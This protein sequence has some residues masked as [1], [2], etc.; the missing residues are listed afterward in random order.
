MKRI[1]GLLLSCLFLLAVAGTAAAQTETPSEAAWYARYWN[2]TTLA[3]APVLMRN[4]VSVNHDWGFGSPEGPV[5]ADRFSARWTSFVEFDAGTY[6]FSLTSDDGARLWVD[7][8]YVID[9]WEIRPATTDTAEV[10]LDAGSHAVAVEYFENTGAAQV[11]L[12]WQRV[13]A[14]GDESVAIS[15]TNGPVGS[16]IAVTATGYSPNVVATVGIGR[17]NS[18]PTT[19]QSVTTDANGTLAT[20]IVL[21]ESAAVGESWV[22]LV[23]AG[24]ESALSPAF[25]VTGE[26]GPGAACGSS[27]VVQPNDWLSR[28]A[29]RCDTTVDAILALNPQISSA[30]VINVG[31]VL[32]LPVGDAAEI[33]TPQI[34][35]T[36]E[37]GLA[38]T[39]VT[40]NGI[41]F[42]AGAA[43]EVGLIDDAGATTSVQ[44]VTTAANGTLQATL[45]IAED[46][47]LGDQWQAYANSGSETVTSEPFTVGISG[48]TAVPQ[49]NLNLRNGPGTAFAATDVV[50]VGTE[51]TVTGVGPDGDW[52]R[53]V[54]DGAEGWIAGWL[55]SIF[56]N[57]DDV[58]VVN[59]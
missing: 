48:V 10:T 43:V 49:F 5:N 16:E 29:R 53:V 27:Y 31:T 37:V 8:A 38:G 11:S 13:D 52:L 46:A 59:G 30:D 12:T 40:V 47:T 28:I 32:R 2:N 26:G 56:G 1:T 24:A 23:R 44:K 51:L 17:A 35:I 39:D 50:P 21:P 18:E 19:E 36:P 22:V 57:M 42:L 41:G 7:D 55:T 9:S 45:S 20:T 15:P 34:T 25:T 6:R 3:G 33:D 58:P 14:P 54:Y 4:E